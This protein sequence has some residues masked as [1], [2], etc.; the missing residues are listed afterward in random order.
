MD[1]IDNNIPTIIRG[2]VKKYVEKFNNQP[3]FGGGICKCR[4]AYDID[5]GFCNEFAEDLVRLLGGENDNRSILSSDMFLCDSYEDAVYHWGRDDLFETNNGATWSKR[6][7]LLY[8]TPAI[9]DIGI[10]DDLPQH[11]WVCVNSKHYDAESPKGVENPWKL[12][13]FKKFFKRLFDNNL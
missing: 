13:I 4:N 10:V 12:L 3:L 7:L 9:E 2:L 8:S 5:N 11:T 6:M 1:E